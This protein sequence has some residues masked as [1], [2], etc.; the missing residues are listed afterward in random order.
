[1]RVFVEKE[2]AKYLEHLN[3]PVRGR[4][5]D[6]LE[7]LANDP[8]EGDIQKLRG[9]EAAFRLRIGAYRILFKQKTSCL[10]VYRIAPRGQAY[11]E[12]K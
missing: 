10:A 2:A 6:A 7:K 11:K 4:I 8:P 1:M 3:E 12:K 9:K 5:V